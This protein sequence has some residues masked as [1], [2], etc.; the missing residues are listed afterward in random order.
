VAS[1][2]RTRRGLALGF[3]YVPVGLG[4]WALSSLEPGEEVEVLGPL[5]HGF[6]LDHPGIPVLVAGGRGIAPLLFAAEALA[7]AG[8]R[9]DIV[10][11]ARRRAMLVGLGEA[12]R[13]LA[14]LGGKLHLAT[15]DGSAGF[16]GHAVAL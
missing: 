14:A 5:G 8:R 7:R 13:R 9:C 6:P 12:R 15:D 10:F 2:R 4:T 16:R 1:C 3:L 11:G